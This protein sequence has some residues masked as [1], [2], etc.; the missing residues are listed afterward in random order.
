MSNDA[1]RI[2]KAA[3]AIYDLMPF[4]DQGPYGVREKPDWVEGGNS[5]KQDEARRYARAALAQEAQGEDER[6]NLKDQGSTGPGSEGGG[7][8]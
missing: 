4:D 1:L 2:E 3:K 6:R 7:H 5:L 8:E